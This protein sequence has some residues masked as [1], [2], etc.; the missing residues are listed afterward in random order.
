MDRPTQPHPAQPHPAGSNPYRSNPYR[1]NPYPD[2]LYP[3]GLVLAGRPVVVVG[4]GRVAARK[5]RSLL[6]AGAAVTVVAPV[7]CDEMRRLPVDLIEREYRRG[8]IDGAWLAVAATGDRAVNA[9]VS[10]DAADARVWLNAADDP[11]ACSFFLPAV[12]RQDPV[13]V[14]VSSGGRSPALASWL[15]DEIAGRM[16]PELAALAQMISEVREEMHAAGRS[17]GSVD[18]RRALDSDMLDLI[19]EGHLARARE[20]LQACLS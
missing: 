1:S 6:D 13:T 2:S 8:D 11:D 15:R 18:W 12:A 3:V 14:A 7:A 16:G 4:A 5:A 19:R 20:R 10:A 17:T 9:D